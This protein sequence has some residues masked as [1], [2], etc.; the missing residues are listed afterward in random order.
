MV[1]TTFSAS[2]TVTVDATA[3]DAATLKASKVPVLTVPSSFNTS[4]A[5]WVVSNGS[6]NNTRAKW[7]DDDGGTTKTL[8]LTKPTGLMVF[9]K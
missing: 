1:S 6:V 9:I 8:Y 7:F 2:G 5:A 3:I 4:S